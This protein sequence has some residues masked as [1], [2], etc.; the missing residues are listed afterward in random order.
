MIDEMKGMVPELRGNTRAT[1]RLQ[2][3]FDAPW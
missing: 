3:S 1:T 2:S